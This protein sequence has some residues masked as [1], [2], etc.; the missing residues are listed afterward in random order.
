MYTSPRSGDAHS[1]TQVWTEATDLL[2]PESKV[3]QKV[4][5]RRSTT[6]QLCHW[7]TPVGPMTLEKSAQSGLDAWRA[8]DIVA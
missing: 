5:I 3:V 6:D 4:V 7:P 8:N 1:H 2:A